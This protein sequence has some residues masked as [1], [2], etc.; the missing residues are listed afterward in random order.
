MPS[1]DCSDDFVGIGGP[2]K[3]LGRRMIGLGDEAVDGGF[4][5]DEGAEATT[6]TKR[7]RS[8]APTVTVIP[9]RILETPTLA[10]PRESSNGLNRQIVSISSDSQVP[11]TRRQ[12]RSR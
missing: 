3:G 10:S 4:E 8:A 6:A 7:A 9:L 1:I 11:A 12:G 2:D 5:L